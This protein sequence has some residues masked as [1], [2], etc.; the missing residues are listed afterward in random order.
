[1]LGV[2]AAGRPL[3][4]ARAPV[5]RPAT[6][7]GSIR[8]AVAPWGVAARDGRVAE[9]TPCGGP[10]AAMVFQ[11]IVVTDLPAIIGDSGDPVFVDCRPAGISS[12]LVGGVLG[13]TPLAEGLDALGSPCVRRPTATSC[14]RPDP[15][16]LRRRRRGAPQRSSIG[17]YGRSTTPV[18]SCRGRPIFVS[19]SR[20]IS[21]QWATQPGARPMANSTVNISTGNPRAW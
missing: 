18:Y 8:R 2:Q 4:V 9:K 20:I 21:R 1:V 3:A 12:Q 19:L 6:P 13:F 16:R 17:M 15:P 7:L 11:C 14:R 10:G 5:P